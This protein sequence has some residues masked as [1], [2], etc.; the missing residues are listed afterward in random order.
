M[1]TICIAAA[2]LLAWSIPALA[3]V[4][5]T[6]SYQG[7]LTDGSGTPVADGS[8]SLAFTIYDAETGGTSLWS[9]TQGAVQVSRGNFSVTLG[10]VTPLTMAFNAPYW[11]GI[12]VNGGAEMTP[13]TNLAA[14]PYALSLRVPFLAQGKSG[15]GVVSVKNDSTGPDLRADH[16]LTVGHPGRSLFRAMDAGSYGFVDVR[17]T[18]NTGYAYMRS[19]AYGAVSFGWPNDG[20]SYYDMRAGIGGDA[21]FTIANNS[22]G[23]VFNGSMT[24]DQALQVPAHSISPVEM[25]GLP[26]IAMSRFVGQVTVGPAP[27]QDIIS[28]SITTPFDGYIMVEASGQAG[29][30]SSVYGGDALN[31]Q[32]DEVS[33]GSGDSGYL[34]VVGFDIIPNTGYFYSTAATERAY[35]KTKGTYT[36]RLKAFKSGNGTLAYFWNPTIRATFFPLSYGGVGTSVNGL[37]AAGFDHAEPVSPSA[38][39]SIPASGGTRY[40][41]DLR[42]LEV[43]AARARAQAMEAENALLQARMRA[44]RA[45]PVTASKDAGTKP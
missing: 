22:V 40:T 36:F 30:Q 29:F 8:Y 2:V 1:R 16:L 6:M 33:G 4:P 37:E 24:G 43:R 27:L 41:V 10:S 14:S 9:E 28:V 3:A 5:Q 12:S 19:S 35:F 11:L 42:E 26:G 18:T 21:F 7:L 38:N 25:T 20:T 17:D 32:I 34:R 31:Y 23:I 44:D 13:R 15:D 45:L 39:G